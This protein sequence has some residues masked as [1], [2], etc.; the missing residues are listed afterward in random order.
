MLDTNIIYSHNQSFLSNLFP[1][2]R[3]TGYAGF[4]ARRVWDAIQKEN[5]FGAENDQCNEKRVFYRL[6]RAF[7]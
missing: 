4:S 2:H 6:A 5:C 7:E 1:L 3:F